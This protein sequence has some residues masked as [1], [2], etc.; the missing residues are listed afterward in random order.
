MP[1]THLPNLVWSTPTWSCDEASLQ[2]A[3]Q[4]E[5]SWHAYK[6]Y[7]AL[8]LSAEFGCWR[9]VNMSNICHNSVAV[10]GKAFEVVDQQRVRL[11]LHFT[12]KIPACTPSI[13]WWIV[14]AVIYPLVQRVEATFISV[15]GMNTLVC[16][17]KEQFVICKCEQMLRAPWLLKTTLVCSL[18]RQKNKL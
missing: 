5:I 7:G 2:S 1:F 13:E 14:V 17:Q 15:Q 12:E 16:E 11:M 10:N 8:A 6:F 18:Q 4:W 9:E 3:V